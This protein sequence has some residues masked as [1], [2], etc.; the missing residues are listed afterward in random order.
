MIEKIIENWLI[1][2]SEKSYQLPFCFLLM[3]E[4][5]T[6][7]HMTRHNSSEHGKDIIAIDEVGQPYAYQLKGI[8]GGRLSI[9][10]WQEI[11]QQVMQMVLT[12][13]AHPS[14]QSGTYHK[15]YLVVNGDIEE[16]VQMAITL[17]NNQWATSGQLQ[18]KIHTIVK[19]Q[20]LEI[21]FRAKELFIPSE[22]TDF[23]SLL[24]FYLEDGKGFLDKAKFSTMIVAL[25][26]KKPDQ[27]NT[28]T[29][30]LISSGALLC[31]LATSSYTNAAN[32]L[33]I[34]EAWTIYLFSVFYAVEKYNLELSDF[35]KEIELAQ[36]FIINTLKELMDEVNNTE[37]LLYRDLADPFVFRYRITML[38]GVLSFLRMVV[39]K[40]ETTPVDAFLHKHLCDT[41][42]WGESAVP[43]FLSTYFLYRHQQADERADE[44]LTSF[45]SRVMHSIVSSDI[46]FP[47]IYTSAEDS[48]SM[49]FG[50]PF[51]ND[52]L[53]TPR[54]SYILEPLIILLSQP[55]FRSFM[56]TQW[57]EISRCFFCSIEFDNPRDFYL[58]RVP[59]G[60]YV[61]RHPKQPQ[62]WNELLRT[63]KEVDMT[64]LPPVLQQYKAWVPLF[65]MVYPHRLNSNIIK[66]LCNE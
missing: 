42:L 41:G 20:I 65:L 55:Q 11:Q 63:V 22:A 5:K 25:L 53:P 10:G 9:R 17:I 6:I 28:E 1:K 40:E 62:S 32:H 16:E 46:L 52:E 14:I 35:K 56:E 3:Q 29:K 21:A 47:D 7:L 15:S 30:R 51:E 38:T 54:I 61:N 66:W 13:C 43:F 23:K 50:R 12:P 49:Q 4:G 24:E 8:H 39:D 59:G 45:F 58:W 57:P 33:A 37:E 60:Q 44:F 19:G 2:A 26:E 64:L 48:V 27:K 18:Y 31:S 36:S 34:V